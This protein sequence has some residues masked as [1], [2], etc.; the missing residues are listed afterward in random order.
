VAY[1]NVKIINSN[2]CVGPQVGTFCYVD[3]SGTNVVLRVVNNSG[4]LVDVYTFTPT[5]LLKTKNQQTSY[6]YN[7]VIGIE[8]LGATN[9]SSTYDGALFLTFE[10]IY[11]SSSS[12]G[13]FIIRKWAIDNN[14]SALNNV[15]SYPH[16]NNPTYSFDSRAFT[17][18]QL[19]R[20]L[21]ASV[22]EGT[23]QITLNTVSGVSIG[24]HL[25]LGPSSDADNLEAVEEVEIYNI[26]GNTLYIRSADPIPPTRYQ[27]VVGD[28]VAVIK[29]GY[30][31]SNNISAA[32]LFLLD[33]S[34]YFNVKS[35]IS[36]NIYR[37]V[38]ATRYSSYLNAISFVRDDI[39]LHLDDTNT[40]FKSQYMHNTNPDKSI[41][42]IYN[43]DFDGST[44]YTLR[45]RY[46]LRS[47]DGT[48]S[49]VDWS[50]YNIVFDTF[51]PYTDS[52]LIVA[53]PANKVVAGLPTA[54]N[55][56]VLDQYGVSLTNKTCSVYIDG[57]VGAVLDP[58]DGI[59]TTDIDGKATVLYTSSNNYEGVATARVRVD[60]SSNYTGSVYV[61]D[62]T[63][64][65]IIN[66]EQVS[67][68]VSLHDTMFVGGFSIGL[69]D[70]HSDYFFASLVDSQ[71]DFMPVYMKEKAKGGFFW[72][73]ED[74]VGTTKE[75][76]LELTKDSGRVDNNITHDHKLTGNKDTTQLN[77][78]VF[79]QE[80]FP[81][82]WSEKN[83]TDTKI[84]LRLRPFIDSLDISTF[85]IEIN[86]K[87]YNGESGWYD[88][89][90]KGTKTLYDAG[91]G[92][93]GVEFE[94]YPVTPFHHNAVIQVR[95]VVYDTSVVPNR[96]YLDYWFN[97]VADYKAPYLENLSPNREE[98]N[99]PVDTDIYFEVK[100]TGAGIDL[101]SLEV[102]VDF[103]KVAYNFTPISDGYAITYSSTENFKYGQ[104][105][106]VNVSVQDLAETP[107]LLED[108]YTFY[109]V[110]S[111]LPDIDLSSA[112]P[113]PCS[114]VLDKNIDKIEFAIY[115][116]GHGID[117]SSIEVY[118]DG[119]TRKVYI[120]PI[121]QR[122]R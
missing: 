62:K 48:D 80:A 28:P 39:L 73:I 1:E 106:T 102:W 104:T 11:N 57:G 72:N 81:P 25:I 98:H 2:F 33:Y 50:T 75:E 65:Y 38:R 15:S 92:L 20:F 58:P 36:S 5:D 31:F 8:Y 121:I 116:T 14:N 35:K 52:V 30:L 61:W 86:E 16:Y 9:Q 45:R 40:A 105:I 42:T 76:L 24:D 18:K 100:D 6:P 101:S 54:L 120:T 78:F 37:N 69:E 22:S 56:K 68:I 113:R 90:D 41:A 70:L 117:E 109:C 26:A 108:S 97:I 60:G 17:I 115:G 83:A 107:N 82:F 44:I 114:L 103:V 53:S 34:N 87:Y 12:S 27:Y 118:V 111:N 89:T 74:K 95:L 13:G 66:D 32:D 47:D 59:V 49:Y 91:G 93:Y 119:K 122:V 10:R 46:N 96:I 88:I 7:R 71:K 29:D 64:I 4:A 110:S 99:V 23:G 19:P 67:Y 85:R 55:I 63:P 94:W 43:I 79:V 84:W 112:T 51:V 3:D 21:G 77:Q